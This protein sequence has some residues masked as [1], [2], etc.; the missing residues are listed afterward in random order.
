MSYWFK[1]EEQNK[2]FPPRR[3]P[4]PIPPGQSY[5]ELTANHGRPNG[6]FDKERQLPYG[7]SPAPKPPK[8]PKEEDYR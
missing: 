7:A 1:L 3:R 5:V 6:P 4:E 2:R 8:P